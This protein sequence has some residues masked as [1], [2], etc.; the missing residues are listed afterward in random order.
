MS[1]TQQHEKG[2]EAG[3]SAAIHDAAQKGSRANAELNEYNGWAN[4][5]T[6]SVNLWLGNE[7]E[8]YEEALDRT[9][10]VAGHGDHPTSQYWT[11]EQSKRF[12]VAEML[13]TWVSD[14]LAPDLGASFPA[15][16]LG[17]ALG[18]VDWDEI[19]DAWI[20]QVAEQVS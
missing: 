7:R 13:K 14:E 5:P 16:L 11:V 4:Y 1:D 9:A 18:Q 19:A 6:W 12:G 15:D 3:Y 2:F 17:Y 20:E 10:A 8:L